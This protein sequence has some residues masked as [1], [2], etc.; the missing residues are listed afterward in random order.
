MNELNLRR[1]RRRSPWILTSEL[2]RKAAGMARC[3]MGT[4]QPHIALGIV[5]AA[6]FSG[7]IYTYTFLKTH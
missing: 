4:P 3:A 1:L 2:G 6:V 7:L 5:T